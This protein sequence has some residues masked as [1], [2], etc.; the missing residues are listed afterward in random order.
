MTPWSLVHGAEPV[1]MRFDVP[2]AAAVERL[3]GEVG[4]TFLAAL[5]SGKMV[6][7]VRADGVSLRRVTPFANAFRPVLE[8]RL[9]ADGDGTRLTG[10]LRIRE[11]ERAFV[12]LWLGGAC[13]STA[14]VVALALR[15][16]LWAGAGLMGLAGTALFAAGLGL[17]W[18]G[19]R[20]SRGDRRW[21]EERI[22]RAVAGEAG[23]TGRS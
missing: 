2:P 20:L 14:I 7:R 4:R 19:R 3:R 8:G 21:L 1:E 22:A 9:E 11:F 13:A 6:G 12:T 18:L 5:V 10:T 16:R 15:D 23:G 17:V